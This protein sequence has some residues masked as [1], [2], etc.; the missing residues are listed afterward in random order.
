MAWGGQHRVLP[1]KFRI[2]SALSIV[3]Y[4]VFAYAALARAEVVP[5]LIAESSLWCSAGF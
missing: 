2:G 1:T 4:A 3:L 5:P